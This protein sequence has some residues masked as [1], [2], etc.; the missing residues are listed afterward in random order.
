MKTGKTLKESASG[1][2]LEDAGLS[3]TQE[4]LGNLRAFCKARKA[5]GVPHFKIE[6]FVMVIKKRG[7]RQPPSPNA[8]GALT[9]LA[10]D[11]GIIKFTGQ[12]ENAESLKTRGHP[13]KVWCAT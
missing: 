8:Y 4:T 13:V 1:I 12:Y 7:W 5:M 2:S 3:W 10:Y 11:A 9:L 6:D